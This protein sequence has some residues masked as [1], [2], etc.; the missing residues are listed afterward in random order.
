MRRQPGL[1]LADAADSRDQAP[2]R[3]EQLFDQAPSVLAAMLAGQIDWR[4]LQPTTHIKAFAVD[5]VLDDRSSPSPLSAQSKPWS[6]RRDPVGARV[7]GH[8]SFGAGEGSRA[9][10]S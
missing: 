5:G 4:W 3:L 6:S 2:E 10:R 1:R 8:G 7:S 9:N